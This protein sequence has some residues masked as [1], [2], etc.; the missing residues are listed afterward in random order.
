MV[1]KDRSH[2]KSQRPP[3]KIQKLLCELRAFARENISRQERQARQE[4]IKIDFSIYATLRENRAHPKTPGPPSK[5]I[6]V[7]GFG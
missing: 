7:Y 1:E 6:L 4:N 3:R 2:A 5:T